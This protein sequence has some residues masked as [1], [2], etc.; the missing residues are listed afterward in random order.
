MKRNS[1]KSFLQTIPTSLAPSSNTSQ[2]TPPPTKKITG[3]LSYDSFQPILILQ[4]VIDKI[5]FADTV[6]C[7]TG[8]VEDI[9][10]SHFST[11]RTTSEDYE[12]AARDFI[13]E[14]CQGPQIQI[15]EK[16]IEFSKFNTAKGF[17]QFYYIIDPEADT[18]K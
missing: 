17:N 10:F 14:L 7:I 8:L 1:H 13:K 2:A 11:Y 16:D 18:N 5:T 4:C 9:P 6:K 15:T 12:T 3:L